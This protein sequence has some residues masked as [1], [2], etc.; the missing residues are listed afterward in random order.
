VTAP[1]VDKGT[2]TARALL[3]LGLAPAQAISFGDMPNDVPMLRVTA[4]GYAVGDSDASV[5]ST[6]TEVLPNVEDDGFARK[7]ADLAAAGW[8]IEDGEMAPTVTR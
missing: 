4:R 8:T 1:G 5:M 6:A 2:G 7:I 3:A